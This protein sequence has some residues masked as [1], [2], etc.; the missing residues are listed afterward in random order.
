VELSVPKDLLEF[1]HV[2]MVM[3][4]KLRVD[5]STEKGLFKTC[6]ATSSKEPVGMY[7]ICPPFAINIGLDSVSSILKRRSRVSFAF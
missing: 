7:I 3:V 5:C 1:D 4:M 6:P 2:P